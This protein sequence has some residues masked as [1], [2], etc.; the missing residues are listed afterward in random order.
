MSKAF[1][2]KKF[3]VKVSATPIK[4]LPFVIMYIKINT[5]E[6]DL[7]HCLS[8]QYKLERLASVG[9]NPINGAISMIAGVNGLTVECPE[10]KIVKN[11]TQYMNY[12]AKAVVKPACYLGEKKGS[13]KKLSED[14]KSFEISVV[15]KCKTFLKNLEDPKSTKIPK[16]LKSLDTIQFKERPDIEHKCS[17]KCCCKCVKECCFKVDEREAIDVV[18]MLESC[19]CKATFDKSTLCVKCRGECCCKCCCSKIIASKLGMYRRLT[20][21]L[22]E[23]NAFVH[24]F[25]DVRGLKLKFEKNFDLDKSVVT[26][27]VEGYEACEKECCEKACE[28]K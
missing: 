28:K 17:K 2:G 27:I 24:V 23:M 20:T 7:L 22:K 13:Y 18:M 3:D 1:K 9:V 4:K 21:D 25:C 12:L 15:G 5:A 8:K 11:I 6:K 26:K 14:M 19:D 16:L 10:N